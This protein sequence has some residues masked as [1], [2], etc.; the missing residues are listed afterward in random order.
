MLPW[1][2]DDE[3]RWGQEKRKGCDEFDFFKGGRE[4]IDE[5]ETDE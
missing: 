3:M 1:L 5:K 4:W 2:F